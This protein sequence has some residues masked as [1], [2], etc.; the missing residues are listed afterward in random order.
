MYRMAGVPG[1]G[2]VKYNFC[3]PVLFK[4]IGIYIH[5]I[6]LTRYFPEI[7]RRLYGINEVEVNKEGYNFFFA[8]QALV[9]LVT[10]AGCQK[11]QR[12]Q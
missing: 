6:N 8:Q 10:L 9:W 5:R 2:G 1:N 3:N 7:Q 4:N 11:K 12:K